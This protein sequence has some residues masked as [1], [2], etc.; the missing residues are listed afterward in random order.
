MSRSDDAQLPPHRALNGAP[1]PSSPTP[2]G[3]PHRWSSAALW[4]G[5]D[6]RQ[7]Q[8]PGRLLAALACPLAAGDSE[9][10][11]T[12]ALEAPYVRLT[13]DW[14]GTMGFASTTME[15]IPTTPSKAGNPTGRATTIAADWSGCLP[16]GG[17]CHHPIRLTIEGWTSSCP[18]R[19][20]HRLPPPLVWSRPRRNTERGTIAGRRQTALRRPH[21]RP[22]PTPTCCRPWRCWPQ[23][24]GTTLHQLEPVRQKETDRGGDAES[25]LL[26]C[27]ARSKAMT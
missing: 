12:N 22:R 19:P 16:A 24:A 26:G 27:S 10:T 14:M 2:R 6:G 18:G 20:R 21:H 8:Q 13:L 1:T 23:A 15:A 3:R 5:G 11:V 17:R 25:S 9:I 4:A 7:Q